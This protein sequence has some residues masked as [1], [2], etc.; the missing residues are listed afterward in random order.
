MNTTSEKKQLESIFDTFTNK[1]A[2]SKTLRFGL[3]PTETTEKLLKEN[4]IIGKDETIEKAYKNAKCYFDLLHQKLIRQAFSFEMNPN[5]S[6]SELENSYKEHSLLSNEERR[7]DA[8]FFSIRKTAYSNVNKLLEDVALLWE[9]EEKGKT[10]KKQG[11]K[12]LCSKDILNLLK[13]EFPKE[14]DVEFVGKDMPSLF[15]QDETGNSKYIFD[16]FDKIN[17]YL[18]KFQETRSNLYLSGG[19]ATAVSSRIVSNFLLF[20]DNKD[21]FKKIEKLSSSRFGLEDIKTEW[22]KDKEK[23]LWKKICLQE[24]I[25]E[26][27]DVIGEINALV[28]KW[29]DVDGGQKFEYPFLKRLKKQVL[30]EVEARVDLIESYADLPERFAEFVEETEI[31]L[32]KTAWTLL[33]NLFSKTYDQDLDKIYINAKAVNSLAFSCFSEPNEFMGTLTGK[34]NQDNPKPKAFT[35]LTEIVRAMEE[36]GGNDHAR[37]FKDRWYSNSQTSSRIGIDETTEY[38]EQLFSLW[39]QQW[40]I[41]FSGEVAKNRSDNVAIIGFNEALIGA[42]EVV[43]EGS[44]KKNPDIV[45]KIK[46]YVDCALD[47]HRRLSAFALEAKNENDIP[48]TNDISTEFY[49]DFNAVFRWYAGKEGKSIPITKKDGTIKMATVF[50]GRGMPLLVRYYNAFR[51]EI[52]KQISDKDKLKIT[53]NA[54]SFLGG[55]DKNKEGEKLGVIFRNADYFYLGVINKEISGDLFGSK[56]NSYWYEDV[57][58]GKWEKME[59]KCLGDAKR[60]IP[61]IAFSKKNKEILGCTKEI[62]KIKKEFEEFQKLKAKNKDFWSVSFDKDKLKKLIE[63]YQKCLDICGY[64]EEYNLSFKKPGEY[65]GIGEFNDEITKKSYKISFVPINKDKLFE[66][67]REGKIFLFRIFNKDWNLDAPNG[68]K[69]KTIKNMHTLYFENLFSTSGFEHLKMN[70]N[71]EMFFR[72]KIV[73]VETKKDK[74]EN[75]VPNHKRFIVDRWLFHVPVKINWN[76]SGSQKKYNVQINNFLYQN[77]E[78]INIIGIDRGEKHLAYYSV[79][80]QQGNILDMGSLNAINNIPYYDLLR[81]RMKERL[82]NRQSWNPIVQIK[83]LKRGYVGA[84]AKKIA[85]LAIRHNAIVVMEDLSFRFKQIRGGIEQSVYQQIEKAL[86]D[87][88]GY[89]VFKDRDANEIGGAMKGYQLTAPFES[90]EKMGKQTGIVFYTNAGYT[91]SI[92]PLTGFRRHIY[93]KV[94]NRRESFLK[95]EEIFWDEKEQ[96]Y[97][98]RY[99]VAKFAYK[100]EEKLERIWSVYG[101]A[102]R[103]VRTVNE[104][105][106][107]E[108]IPTSV[109]V[110][111]EDLFKKYEFDERGDILSQM[112]SASEEDLSRKK[113][114]QE[115]KRVKD[116]NFWE[117]LAYLFSVACEVRNS[118]SREY[119]INEET[120]KA[121]SVGEDVDFIASPVPPFFATRSDNPKG[122]CEENLAGFER[123]FDRFDGTKEEK[124]KCIREFNGDA[125]GAYNIARKGIIILE[126]IRKYN[127]REGSAEKMEWK[128]LAVSNQD[129]DEYTSLKK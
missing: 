129:W 27:N 78:D 79:V 121:E 125:N 39:K 26:Y 120:G 100:K 80:D 124:Q 103:I 105:G 9:N 10:S 3:E 34:K 49:E 19:E 54:G 21:V 118:L 6:L 38:K 75:D 17:G 82:E 20:L 95:F 111:L 122:K 126:K 53:F 101:K 113:S 115:G 96:S 11:T 48:Q 117:R 76:P 25:D 8:T 77:L 91:S 89:L 33:E 55:W 68:N 23:V 81:A 73:T 119:R 36:I 74:K 87:K 98:F 104:S 99:D 46:T 67:E 52:T 41:L 37:I 32:G 63:Y 107:W 90:F 106:H 24:G 18:S 42:K 65:K 59:Y 92:D 112:K 13:K 28:K 83:N 88:L 14:M 61:R 1:Y 51:N 84:L 102:S 43:A 110:L 109:D 72:K 86:I 35:S 2:L 44:F 93:M 7:K 94:K 16:A 97:C 4:Q 45:K 71:A 15:V 85:D 70:G 56:K 69:K 12:F 31:R 50:D 57:S 40:N 66:K 128:D 29:R 22:L 108:P 116:R 64:R 47:I 62:E 60:Q 127:N 5:F 114:F 58:D 123:R 30:S